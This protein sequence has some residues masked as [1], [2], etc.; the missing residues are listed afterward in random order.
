[1]NTHRV[2]VKTNRVMVITYATYWKVQEFTRTCCAIFTN[3]VCLNER[4]LQDLLQ[5]ILAGNL[6]YLLTCSLS[7]M[8]VSSD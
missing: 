4:S 6:L 3:I 1:M 8:S 2:E 5:L 7:A